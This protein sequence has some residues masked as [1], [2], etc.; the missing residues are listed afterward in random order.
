MFEHT[1]VICASLLDT[2]V[3]H[4]WTDGLRLSSLKDFTEI[5]VQT[6]NS[7]YRITV[8]DGEASEILIRG[9]KCFPETTRAQ[10]RGS[11]LRGSVLKLGHIQVG[12][13][14][15][16]LAGESVVVTSKVQSLSINAPRNE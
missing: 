13:N 16:V 9:G 10:L 8:I 12:F 6:R 5:R 14:F 15:E 2:W 11:S 3:S 7:T 1:Q 4:D